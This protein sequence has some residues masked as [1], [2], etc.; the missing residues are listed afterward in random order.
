MLGIFSFASGIGSHFVLGGLPLNDRLIEFQRVGERM[1]VLEK[2]SRFASPD[3]STWE[4][5]QNLTFGSSVW[6]TSRSR[7]STIRPRRWLVDF[8]QFPGERRFRLADGAGYSLSSTPGAPRVDPVRQGALADASVKDSAGTSIEAL[9]TYSPN[10]RN[11][12]LMEGVSDE[13]YIPI[14]V[15]YSF[16][17]LPEVPMQPRHADDRVGYFLTAR[18]DFGNDEAENFWS[19]Y[20]NRWRLEKKDPTATLS[21]PVKPI[22]YYIDPTVPEKYR[23]WVKEGVEKW[24]KAFEA[25]GFKNAIRGRG[26]SVGFELGHPRTCATAR[27]AGP[28]TTPSFGGVGALAPDPRTGEILDADILFE[29]S[30]LQN[31]RN[32]YRRYSGPEEMAAE[33]LPATRMAMG[34]QHVPMELRCN[35]Q[36]GVA[37]GGALMHAGLLADGSL[38]PGSPVPDA[39]MHDAVV[40]VTMHEVGHTLGLPTP[41]AAARRRRTTAQRQGLDRRARDVHVGDGVPDAQHLRSTAPSRATT[42]R[43]ARAQATCG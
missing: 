10:S 32:A 3:G 8:G 34:P 40:W 31:Y 25:A 4:K 9:L 38:P 2:N 24:Q 27:S 12:L 1:L 6:P 15:H 35:A 36:Q 19:R 11:Q 18:K 13:R 29:A 37:D 14:K 23:P 30:M 28:S 39:Y 26:R 7:A 16:S 22:T 41:S 17:K 5:A 43:P 42:T 33:I 21:E 20:V